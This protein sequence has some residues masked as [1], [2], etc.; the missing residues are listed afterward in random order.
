MM[1][2]DHGALRHIRQTMDW[3]QRGVEQAKRHLS[4]A[5]EYFPMTFD[6]KS[7]Y[8]SVVQTN[9]IV[10]LT[11]M[12]PRV[13]K[14]EDLSSYPAELDHLVEYLSGGVFS[15]P[16]ALAREVQE[17]RISVHAGGEWTPRRVWDSWPDHWRR[18]FPLLM[19]SN[20]RATYLGMGYELYD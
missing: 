18:A 17:L 6:D 15:Y 7:F 16:E 13:F 9:T 10:G 14:I 5:D 19:H 3:W 1:A 2:L 11:R 8:R 4:D 20:A 12:I